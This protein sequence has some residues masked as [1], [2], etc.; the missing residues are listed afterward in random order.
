[1]TAK[2]A[3]W[4]HLLTHRRQRLRWTQQELARSLGLS[5]SQ[6][7]AALDVPRRA[8]AV[9]VDGRGFTLNDWKKLL[10][11]WAVF[12]D[13][14]RDVLWD[15]SF[16]ASA[17]EIEGEMVPEAVFSGPSALK[18][19][20]D[21]APADY[22]RVIVYLPQ[23]DLPRLQERLAPLEDRRG[24]T[25]LTVLSPDPRQPAPL[26]LE[27]VYVDV[28]QLPDW[29]AAEYLRYIM[30]ALEWE[31]STTTMPSPTAAGERSSNSAQNTASSS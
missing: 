26:P 4:R 15:A 10:V 3:V 31:E 16:A 20:R 28:W 21:I 19:A 29:W 7:H 22:D 12:R 11:I 8:G 14:R 5:A 30:E 24:P 25:R 17:S 1:V 9:A 18:F 27:Q 23:A 6:V 2:E 13:W